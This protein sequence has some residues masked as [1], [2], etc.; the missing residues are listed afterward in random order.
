M[1]NQKNA[2]DLLRRHKN[3]ISNQLVINCA[4]LALGKS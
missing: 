1:R 2:A 4:F 3:D